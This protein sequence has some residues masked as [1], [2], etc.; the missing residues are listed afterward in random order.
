M[1]TSR[2]TS[3]VGAMLALAG[4]TIISVALGQIFHAMPS[5]TPGGLPF[6]DIAAVL[7][8]AFFGVKLLKETIEMD[9][10]GGSVMDEELAD[11]EEAVKDHKSLR[12]NNVWAQIAST[13]CLVFA[14]EFG[15]RSF[16]TTIALSAAQNPFSVGG[17]AV[18]AHG[19]ATG[20]AVLGGGAIA[21]YISEKMI[22][23]ISGTLFVVFAITT[24]LGIF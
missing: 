2:V 18:A 11:A 9:D 17:G 12:V 10:E 3:F 20:I 21:K 15:D 22:G 7:A 4:M 13:C 19:V 24:A 23:Y 1:K 14:A 8:F 16:F 5:V 6:D